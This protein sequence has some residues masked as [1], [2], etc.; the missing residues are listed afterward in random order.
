[1]LQGFRDGWRG[2]YLALLMMT[3]R[4]TAL[5]KAAEIAEKQQFGSIESRY[6]QIAA[7]ILSEYETR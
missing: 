4:T 6:E 5:A 2:L 3:Y 7:Q 1:V